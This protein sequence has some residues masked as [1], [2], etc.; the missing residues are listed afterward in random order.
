[1]ELD[2]HETRPIAFGQQFTFSGYSMLSRLLR[3]FILFMNNEVSSLQI[4]TCGF[5]L[6]LYLLFPSARSV[7]LQSFTWLTWVAIGVGLVGFFVVKLASKINPTIIDELKKIS[8]TQDLWE[9]A[10]VLQRASLIAIN[11]ILLIAALWVA[12][13][14]VWGFNFFKGML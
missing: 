2:H 6:L 8:A 4:V 12:L 10:S 11:L 1:L 9:Q 14:P 13:F 3:H 5:T 7:L